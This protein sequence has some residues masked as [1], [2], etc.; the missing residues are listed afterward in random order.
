M[1][2]KSGSR[3]APTEAQKEAAAERRAKIRGLCTIIKNLP[4]EKRLALAARYGIRTCEGRELSIYNQCLLIHQNDKVSMVGGFK[5]WRELGRTVRKGEKALAIWVPCARGVEAGEGAVVPAGADP[6]DLA[7]KFFILGNVFDITQTETEAEREAR[8]NVEAARGVLALPAP[9]PEPAAALALPY[10]A[11]S[12]IDVEA[13][14]VAASSGTVEP[15]AAPASSQL[16][17][18]L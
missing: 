16:A 12:I 17:F 9:A 15:S 3:R 8:E 13:E 2:P 4:E 6:A 7:D 14:V 1:K 5:Q 10:R 11:A 18:Q